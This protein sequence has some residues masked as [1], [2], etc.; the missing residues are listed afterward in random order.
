M[1]ASVYFTDHNY[2]WIPDPIAKL[3]SDFP[4]GK[5]I[6]S[7]GIS[8]ECLLLAHFLP[9]SLLHFLPRISSACPLAL[10]QSMMLL[11]MYFKFIS[12]R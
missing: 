8:S 11:H 10:V 4:S 12:T 2:F 7:D 6:M 1:A 9:S 3:H 5:Q